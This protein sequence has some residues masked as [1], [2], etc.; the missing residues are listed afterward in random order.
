MTL[1]K[2]YIQ[3]LAAVAL[4]SATALAAGCGSPDKTTQTT[5]ERTTTVPAPP[6]SSSTTT[7]TTQNSGH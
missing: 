3:L 6:M 7:T 4:L 1:S 5:T 2:P